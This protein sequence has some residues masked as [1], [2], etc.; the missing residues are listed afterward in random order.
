MTDDLPELPDLPDEVFITD[1]SQFEALSS[2][3]RMRIL[4]LKA[5]RGWSV[6]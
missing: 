1:P 3:L 5:A 2:G 6:I 4:Q